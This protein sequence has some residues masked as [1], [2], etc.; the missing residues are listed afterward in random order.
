MS[1]GFEPVANDRQ[2]LPHRYPKKSCGAPQRARSLIKIAL[3]S[4]FNHQNHSVLS[5]WV[6]GFTPGE[7]GGGPRLV[8]ARIASNSMRIIDCGLRMI[9]SRMGAAL[10]LLPL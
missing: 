7:K 9:T 5:L 3:F 1:N 8:P 6:Q 10:S 4:D 2:E